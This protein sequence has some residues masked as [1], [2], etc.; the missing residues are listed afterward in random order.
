MSADQT[1]EDQRRAEAICTELCCQLARADRV[2]VVEA[3][4]RAHGTHYPKLLANGLRQLE[5]TEA[6]GLDE[7]IKAVL[8]AQS[9]NAPHGLPLLLDLARR[10]LA[11]AP[12]NP[13]EALVELTAALEVLERYGGSCLP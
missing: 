12:A 1:N 3:W 11:V 10:C 4:A 8:G 7:A 2:T 6:F 5:R 9:T 13:S